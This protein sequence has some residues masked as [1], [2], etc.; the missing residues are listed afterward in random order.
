MWK[1]LTA[2]VQATILFLYISAS[3][4]PAPDAQAILKKINETYRNLKSYQFEYKTV[5]D[6]RTERDGL[7]ST[8][9]NES[10]SRI[11]AV[12]PDR[13]RVETQDSLSSV[14][15]IADGHTVWL[16][17]SQMNAY[18]KRAPGTVDI[19]AV[20]KPTDSRYESMARMVNT[21]LAGYARLTSEPRNLTLLPDETINIRGRQTPCYVIS[22]VRGVGSNK[23][24]TRY[25][26]DRERY[27]VLRESADQ[28]FQISPGSVTRSL[29]LVDFISAAINEPALD[30]AFSYTPPNGAIEIDRLEPESLAS[31]G[32]TPVKWIGQEAPDFTLPDLNGKPVSLQSLRGKAVLLNFWAT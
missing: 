1:V 3:A 18:T 21:K 5:I 8:Q 7:T 31:N 14:L 9:H 17:S 6:L 22:I 32:N 27:L 28:T 19:F 23:D 20:A 2:V 26:I 10:M 24:N 12:R 16:Y 15:F 25:W 4:Q 11:T 29:R 30:S 13:I